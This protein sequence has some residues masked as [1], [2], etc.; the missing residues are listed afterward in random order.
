MFSLIQ[1]I[2]R[3]GKSIK[4]MC[5]TAVTRGWGEEEVGDTQY[6]FRVTYTLEIHSGNGPTR[7]QVSLPKLNCNLRNEQRNSFYSFQPGIKNVKLLYVEEKKRDENQNLPKFC[8]LEIQAISSS[9]PAMF[10]KHST[11]PGSFLLRNT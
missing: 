10:H 4:T 7:L 11:L 6:L 9:H 3:I 2:S 5:R 1:G 8:H